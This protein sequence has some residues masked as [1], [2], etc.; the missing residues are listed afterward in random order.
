MTWAAGAGISKDQDGKAHKLSDYAG[1]P[2][3]VNSSIRER[4]RAVEGAEFRDRLP[5]LK[6]ARAAV[7]SVN[8]LDEK[9]KRN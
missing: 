9:S 6:N 8:I 7:I 1:K 5:Q 3:V 4:H 2:L